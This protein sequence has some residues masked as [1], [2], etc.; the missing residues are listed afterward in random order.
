MALGL[1]PPVWPGTTLPVAWNC[2]TQLITVLGATRNRAATRCRDRPPSKGAATARR[3]SIDK[4]LAIHAGLL[5]SQ[6][7]E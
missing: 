4:G 2:R 1:W 7:V 3:R 6:P 5:S